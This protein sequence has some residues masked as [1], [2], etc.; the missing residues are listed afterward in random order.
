MAWHSSTT[1]KE[2]ITAGRHIF[3]VNQTFWIFLVRSSIGLTIGG[4][5]R[6]N[7]ILQ[8]ANSDLFCFTRGSFDLNPNEVSFNKVYWF[9]RRNWLCTFL[10]VIEK[11]LFEIL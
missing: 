3:S 9:W 6:I 7:H 8:F 5:C 1:V 11:L 2:L 10:I 4:F